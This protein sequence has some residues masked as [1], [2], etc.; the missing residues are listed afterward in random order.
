MN[1]PLAGHKIGFVGLG[2]MGRA[3]ARHLHEAGAYVVVWNRSA[4]PAEAAVALGMRRAANLPDLARE[5]GP[6]VIC[7][8]L[9]MTDVVEKIVF[10]PGGLIEGLHK[11]ALI[12]DFGTTGVPETKKWAERVNWVDAPVSG[13]QVGAEAATLTIM[14]GGSDANF[15]RALPIFQACG[16]NITHLGPSGS[17]QVTKLANQL[18]V[19]QTIDAVA[20]ALRLAELSGVDP[21][22]V[23]KALLGGFAESRILDLHGDRMVRRDFAPGGRAT[24]QL[25]DVRLMSQLADSVGLDSPTLRNSLA[26]WEKFVHEKGFGDLDHSGLFRL[27]EQ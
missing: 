7:I 11:D 8:N 15:Q 18:I 6:G 3:N 26:Q 12:I 2:N 27:Y 21:A 16:K 22:L 10:G 4:A 25:K 14:A 17:G 1:Q 13:G 19:A 24:L 5:I 20:Q 9:T 23:R